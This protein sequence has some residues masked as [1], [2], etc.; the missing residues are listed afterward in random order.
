MDIDDFVVLKN[1]PYAYAWYLLKEGK[2]HTI[3]EKNDV[4]KEELKDWKRKTQQ[5]HPKTKM[6]GSKKPLS[7]E[8]YNQATKCISIYT[9]YW[10]VVVIDVDDKSIT[11]PSELDVALGTQGLFHDSMCW[12]PGNTKG[13]HIYVNK[14]GNWQNGWEGVNKLTDSGFAIDIIYQKRNVW[15]RPDKKIYNT[16]QDFDLE[17]LYNMFASKKRKERESR[18]REEEVQQ[19]PKRL[20]KK[21]TFEDMAKCECLVVT[22]LQ[23]KYFELMSSDYDDW[24]KICYSIVNMRLRDVELYWQMIC[25]QVPEKQI[26][27]RATRKEQLDAVI[28][29]VSGN[30]IIGRGYN[31]GTLF[32]MMSDALNETDYEKLCEDVMNNFGRYSYAYMKESFD[33]NHFIYNGRITRIDDGALHVY[34]HND[35]KVQYAPMKWDVKFGKTIR[36]VDFLQ[37]YLKDEERRFVRKIVMRPDL[38]RQFDIESDE[39]PETY[40]SFVGFEIEKHGDINIAINSD[41][42]CNEMIQTIWVNLCNEDEIAF[43]Y[44]IQWFAHLIFCP[45]EM[46]R[47]HTC[48]VFYSQTEGVGKS[49]ILHDLILKKIIGKTYGEKSSKMEEFFGTFN[50]LIENK[51]YILLEEGK[52][53][54][55]VQF[56]DVM[57]DALVSDDIVIHKKGLNK[58]STNNYVHVCCAT[59]N[60]TV[61]SVGLSNRRY[62]IIRC[63]EE[64]MDEERQHKLR[65]EINDPKQVLNFVR[66]LK[67][68]LNTKWNSEEYVL[69]DL[70]KTDMFKTQLQLQISQLDQFLQLTYDDFASGTGLNTIDRYAAA[71]MERHTGVELYALFRRVMENAGRSKE[72]IWTH[73]RF[74]TMLHQ[75]GILPINRKYILDPKFVEEHLKNQRLLDD[76]EENDE[77]NDE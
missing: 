17:G 71:Y 59:N 52:R 27:T 22:A 1:A 35:A 6:P 57:K 37:H 76:D 9:K 64:K 62:A 44:V 50:D 19:S 18:E 69:N 43:K 73:T 16:P 31:I 72:G 51:V 5:L 33:K 70:Q 46:G 11:K 24:I 67:D 49:F 55:A 34:N 20:H 68:S 4:P 7:E 74:G 45:H 75:I 63:K 2:K 36:T 29:S 14:P 61:F 42:F 38:P 60:D 10:D 47:F 65:A 56:T 8:E 32:N 30:S 66:Y 48:L 54:D 40:N 21:L 25:Q 15:E 13:I 28:K 3:L 53:A 23:N 77:E 12:T 58:Y 26:S 41:G 39:Y